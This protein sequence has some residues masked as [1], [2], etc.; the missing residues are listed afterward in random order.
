MLVDTINVY[1]S[2]DKHYF[3]Q[4]IT[5][6]TSMFINHKTEERL[7]VHILTCDL[8]EKENKIAQNLAKKYNAEIEFIYINQED[9]EIYTQNQNMQYLSINTFFRF[10]ILSLVPQEI[11][12]VIYLDCDLV[13]A[14]EISELYNQDIENY[15]AG[16]IED[17]MAYEQ[18]GIL[19]LKNEKYFNA[20]VLLLNLGEIRKTKFEED[21]IDYFNKNKRFLKYHDQDIL[22]AIWDCR[23]KFLDERF[24]AQSYSFQRMKQRYKKAGVKRIKNPVIIHY[25]GEIKPWHIYCKHIKV[26][27]WLKYQQM[28]E[29]KLNKFEL[30]LFFLKR[31]LSKIFYVH[32]LISLTYIYLFGI[33]LKVI[34]HKKINKINPKIADT[35]EKV[36]VIIPC[37]NQGKYVE[38]AI[39][40][41][42]AQT[43][44]N[45]EIVCVNDSST[46]N[47]SEIIKSVAE[48]HSNIVCLDNKENRG[49][50]YSRNLAI[51]SSD[52]EYILPLDADDT[53]EPT[54]IEKAVKILAANPS[55]GIVYCKLREFGDKEQFVEITPFDKSN[56]L[57]DNCIFNSALFRKS[58]FLQVGKYK[59][60]MYEGWEDYDLWL[61]FVAQGFDVYRIE[62]PLFNYRK[63]AKGTRSEYAR[64][65]KKKILKQIIKNHIDLYLEDEQFLDRLFSLNRK[66]YKKYKRL[67]NVFLPII[68]IESLLL[69]IIFIYWL[70]NAK[71]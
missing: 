11:K 29:Y 33:K 68:I 1:F 4:C 26:S 38:E 47:S 7:S 25:T 55:I 23:V 46:D 52:G 13:V 12:K 6:I 16:V 63:F 67:F 58:D 21:V 66:K 45:I 27:E 30:F 32:K 39:N 65:Y 8:G 49:V 10:H 36:S 3:L 35:N 18:I 71:S 59:D 14:G 40:S 42:L 50:I 60:Y 54:Y 62:E 43:Y 69:I 48:K 2:S 44:K 22:N 57:Y 53:I 5:A 17:K 31:T 37:Y 19:G 51:M 24:N 70:Q 56:F 9:F 34:S 64:K 28:T 41:V 61:S 15:C 20:G